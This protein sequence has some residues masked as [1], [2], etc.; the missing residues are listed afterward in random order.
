MGSGIRFG[1]SDSDRAAILVFR[2]ARKITLFSLGRECWVLAI[3][4]SVNQRQGWPSLFLDWPGNV[5]KNKD[6]HPC[7]WL[8]KIFN[9][10]SSIPR[11]TDFDETWHEASIQYPLP[12]SCFWGDQKTN[13][14]ELSTLRHAVLVMIPHI[15][16][17]ASR[18]C[19]ISYYSF[20]H[21]N[22]VLCYWIKVF[23]YNWHDLV[24]K[25]VSMSISHAACCHHNLYI[26]HK[27]DKSL[28]VF[29]HGENFINIMLPFTDDPPSGASVKAA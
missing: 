23:I 8:A 4:F 21:H 1:H 16:W 14:Y 25:S 29:W 11:R 9:F 20:V 19:L 13:M 28:L 18:L 5:S 26:Y 24:T 27:H 3:E 12:S 2:S 7:L 22:T 6:G 10:S 17:L 15:V